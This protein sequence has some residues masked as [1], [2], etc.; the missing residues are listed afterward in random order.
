M[1]TFSGF[2][3]GDTLVD[4]AEIPGRSD[5]AYTRADQFTGYEF[6]I[7]QL[8]L[9]PSI[10]GTFAITAEVEPPVLDFSGEVGG[11]SVG[12]FDWFEDVHVV[13]RS[14]SLGN[15]LS[16]QT[17]PVEVYSA[18]RD[19]FHSWDA[20]V[21][22]AGAGVT[23]LN[24]PSLPYV[25]PPQSGV[26][27]QLQV[28]TNGPPVVDTTLDWVFDFATIYTDIDF[29]RVVL[30][31]V[32]P[33]LP[34]TEYLE[35]LTDVLTHKDGT[36]QRVALRKNPRQFFEWNLMLD[37]G[38]ERTRLENILF[39]WQSRIFGVPVWHEMTRLTAAAAAAATSVSVQSTN[40]ADYRVGS[41]ALV[42]TSQTVFDVMEV[43]SFTSTSVSFATPLLNSHAINAVVCPLRTGVMERSP[44]EGRFHVNA[45]RMRALFRVLDN[46]ANLASTAAFSSFNG[47]VLL[48][49]PNYVPGGVMSVGFRQDGLSIDNLTGVTFQDPTWPSHRRASWKV[50]LTNTRQGLWNVRQLLHA[51]RGRQVSLYLPTFSKDLE[52]TTP[53]VNGANTMVVTN[54][55]YNQFVRQRPARNVIRV[56]PNQ[57]TPPII[58]N[59]TASVDGGATE[60]L[61]INGT[62]SSG[63]T[64]AQVDR[65][66][67]VEKV[68][69]DSDRVRIDYALGDRTAKITAPVLTVLE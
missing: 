26:Q 27:M 44:A 18:F 15:V 9:A 19:A 56:V 45:S 34:Y 48:D 42:Y 13:P 61:T 33:E 10:S 11:S 14:F 31:A 29:E 8:A 21:N 54:V 30:F 59:V 52:L 50:F 64:P 23:L 39:D 1:A 62:W 6:L 43:A 41:L 66:E 7:D 17:I 36:E 24:A 28:A 12:T 4:K 63:L 69:L 22:N 35:W 55:G 40:F 51:L 60:T 46:D 20:W 53:I 38:P 47:K 65:V 68:R 49:V 67:F 5:Q 58:K 25:L 32:V 57:G 16:T 2:L 3:T 37:E